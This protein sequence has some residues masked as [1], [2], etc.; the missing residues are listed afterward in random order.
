MIHRCP[1]ASLVAVSTLCRRRRQTWLQGHCP[2]LC[3]PAVLQPI[4]PPGKQ[5]LWVCGDIRCHSQCQM[6]HLSITCR[7]YLSHSGKHPRYKGSSVTLTKLLSLHGDTRHPSSVLHLHC[8]GFVYH[9]T[10]CYQRGV[11]SSLSS[12][13]QVIAVVMDMFTD[14]DIFKDLL[15]AGFKR[16]VGVYIILDETN[17]KHFLQMCERAQMHTGHM[18]VRTVLNLSS[19]AGLCCTICVGCGPGTRDKWLPCLQS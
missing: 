17:V 3:C 5:N 19:N 15:D 10:C 2:I 4:P 9:A 1:S 13:L 16:K 6:V 12:S 8:A 7:I 14:V 18:K 11:E